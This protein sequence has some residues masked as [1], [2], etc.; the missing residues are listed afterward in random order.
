MAMMIQRG[1]ELIRIN[2]QKNHIEYSTD[3]GRCWHSRYTG[4]SCGSF[5]DLFDFGKEL[6]CC[7]AKGIY[8]ST[9][10]GRCWHSRY[11]SSSCGKFQQLAADG[12]R[13]LATTEKGL[14]YS[15]DGGRCWHKR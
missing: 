5:Y 9:D 7:C 6:L 2:T 12:S 10:E 4:S 13:I 3:G 15:T 8:Y 1:R 11:T 14:Y